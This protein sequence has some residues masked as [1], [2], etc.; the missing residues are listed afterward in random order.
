MREK[1]PYLVL[2]MVSFEPFLLSREPFYVKLLVTLHLHLNLSICLFG[3]F[4]FC[5]EA[6]FHTL[7]IYSSSWQREK[8]AEQISEW[9]IVSP[10]LKCLRMFAINWQII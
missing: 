10:I 1:L 9:K 7:I 5:V 4:L 3:C 6:H 2:E 8:K